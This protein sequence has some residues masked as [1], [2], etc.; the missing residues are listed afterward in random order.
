MNSDFEEAFKEEC[1]HLQIVYDFFHIKKNLNEKV[2]D[3]IRK[4][5]QQK[6]IENGDEKAARI[7]KRTK[8][9]LCSSEQT[10]L[11]KIRK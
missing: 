3:E 1:P 10:L 5:E 8:Y 6:L 11:K 2:I 9:I 4:D 7:L